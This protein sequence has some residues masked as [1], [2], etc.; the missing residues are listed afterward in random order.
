[1]ASSQDTRFSIP[2]LNDKDY[3]RYKVEL[4]LWKKITNV[5]AQKQGPMVALSLPDNHGSKIK[6]K[7]L[8]ELSI[9]V[10]SQADGLDKL[11]TFM[12]SVLL[13]DQLSDA[14]DKYHDFEK[15][16]R[17]NEN[18]SEYIEEFDLKYKRLAKFGIKL[19]QE[20]LAF[21]LLI[22]ADITS[23][24]Q[25]IVKSGINYKEK[26]TMYDQT[27]ASLKKFK[28]ESGGSS[29]QNNCSYNIKSESVNVNSDSYRDGFRRGRGRGSFHGQNRN[30]NMSY[31]SFEKN[32]RGNY[33]GYKPQRGGQFSRGRSGRFSG[34][35]RQSN[36]LDV[37]GKIMRCHAC[38]ST[39]H[40]IRECP[41]SYENSKS[42]NH[43]EYE[44]DEEA[45]LFTGQHPDEM[46][47]FYTESRNSAVLDSACSSTVCGKSWLNDY[48]NSLDGYNCEKVK[49]IDSQKVFR[50]GGGQ[51]LKSE[52]QY[53]LPAIM[54]GVRINIRTDVV[55][56]DIPLLLSKDA[57]K[58]ANMKLDLQFD[59]AEIFGKTVSLNCT[60]SGHYCI[61]IVEE[62]AMLVDLDKCSDVEREK[63]F[64]KLHYQ[65]GHA[66]SQKL[67]DL[68]KDAKV[69]NPNFKDKMDQICKKCDIC[70]QYAKTP[71]RSVVSFPLASSFNEVVSLDLK[72]WD[73][74]Y[75]LHMIDV[76]SRY[77]MSTFIEKK[78]P[79]LVIDSLMKRWIA[80]F[81]VMKG[82][83]SDN[84]GEFTAEEM[85]DVASKL[86]VRLLTTAAKSPHQNG[87]NERVHY[88]VDSML[89]KLRLQFPKVKLDVLLGWAN[90]AKNSIH[91]NHGFSSHQL[92]FGSNPTLPNILTDELPALDD[93]TIS[94][95]FA[96]HLKCLHS[97]RQLFIQ[98][99]SDERI[100]RA[101]R[102]KTRNTNER[103]SHGDEVY[104][105]K[106]GSARWLGPA[107]VMF[108]DGKVIFVRH[109]SYLM[110]V[111]P[112]RLVKR[113]CDRKI[114]IN[115]DD[116]IEHDEGNNI[117]SEGEMVTEKEDSNRQLIVNKE[118]DNVN[119]GDISEKNDSN[120]HLSVV[121]ED[122][123]NTIDHSTSVVEDSKDDSSAGVNL[124][125]E[126][127]GNEFVP[128][129]E[130]PIV[131]KSMRLLNRENGWEV[132]SVQL[133]KAMQSEKNV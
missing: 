88:I 76:W 57:M 78:M 4:K 118:I 32:V 33:G 29:V 1:M 92:V 126:A 72:Q 39:R 85:M 49:R 121:G 120:K 75:I 100:R 130:Q 24:E 95:V 97:A 104:Y 40:L 34:A 127:E 21:K 71:A 111:T 22:H 123:D 64:K 106:D 109:G 23:D 110:R 61:P 99:E 8:E 122:L 54:A 3:E 67:I 44:Q 13:K 117:L 26:E 6:D 27:K 47:V 10:L 12:D 84:G 42:V 89:Y 35:G 9:D 86:G 58:K 62:N 116:S 36:P 37:Q 65:F 102:H 112:N 30:G 133:S 90:M 98:S 11:I 28:G 93:C 45:C 73:G 60:S 53:T 96:Q 48:I 55:D 129:E 66:S 77:S 19:P 79:Q 132:Y 69:W 7:V 83:I 68:L 113:Y 52:G 56:S 14:F 50:F 17:N 18:I 119:S 2:T 131:R 87:L 46:F 107:R 125:S 15:Y 114:N 38:E 31:G 91:M 124:Q 74:G 51:R 82:I 25:M 94:E 59:T 63:T 115:T 70:K 101:L 81:G 5:P 43:N 108:Q 80:I 103:F 105:K 16:N 41:H 20:I 128:D